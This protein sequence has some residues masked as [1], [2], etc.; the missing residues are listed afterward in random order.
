MKFKFWLKYNESFLEW[1]KYELI[2]FRY[3]YNNGTGILSFIEN[4]GV[5]IS[6]IYIL[7]NAIIEWGWIDNF[8]ASWYVY[9]SIILIFV[10][11]WIGYFNEKSKY[12]ILKQ[13]NDYACREM[14]PYNQEVL[15]IL[16]DTNAKIKELEQRIK[17][18][19]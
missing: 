10:K 5:S 18:L 13:E 16:K 8:P 17:E 11:Y 1:T 19:R 9:I 3:R 6:V 2:K 12:G 15:E 7:K 4:M 14:N